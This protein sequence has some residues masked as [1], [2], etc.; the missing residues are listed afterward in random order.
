[1]TIEERR[2]KCRIR[3]ILWRKNNRKKCCLS[4]AAW[5][6]K[7]PEYERNLKLKLRYDITP[8]CYEVM[9]ITQIISV[10][11][12]EIRKQQDIIIQNAYKN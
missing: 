4:T 2:E 7:N 3:N 10:Q 8:E 11:F 1:M 12:V 9:K 5:R 6:C